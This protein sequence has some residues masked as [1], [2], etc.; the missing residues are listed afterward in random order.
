MSKPLT[1]QKLK[2]QFQKLGRG[3]LR[4]YLIQ[5]VRKLEKYKVG[6]LTEKGRV[7]L[8][9]LV[10]SLLTPQPFK[11]D[12]QFFDEKNKNH[13]Y[14]T[15]QIDETATPEEIKKAYR[16]LAQQW[17]PDKNNSPEATEKFQEIGNAYSKLTGKEINEYDLLDNL[18]DALNTLK[19]K[20][21]DLTLAAE[22]GATLLNENATLKQNLQLSAE[23]GQ[24]LLN[25]KIALEEKIEKISQKLESLEQLENDNRELYQENQR[26]KA[27]QNSDT[28]TLTEL[29]EQIKELSSQ[30]KALTSKNQKLTVANQKLAGENQATY[31]LNEEKKKLQQELAAT[32]KELSESQQEL[33]QLKEQEQAD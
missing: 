29:T 3:Q 14:Q 4:D 32:K 33:K 6:R 1:D 15:L 22:I 24:T 19:N 23:Y 17:H 9:K 16:K 30:N 7:F 10:K 11:L 18:E 27:N 13:H 26:L 21:Q 12:L 25:Q 28:Q 31:S 5:V 20:D 8:E 2:E